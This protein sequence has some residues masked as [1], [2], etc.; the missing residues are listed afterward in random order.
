MKADIF[1]FEELLTRDAGDVSGG[2]T[3]RKAIFLCSV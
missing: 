1:F 2:P 3:I